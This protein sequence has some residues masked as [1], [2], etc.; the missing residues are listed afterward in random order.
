MDAVI[1]P[2]WAWAP[3]L[4]LIAAAHTAHGAGA[5]SSRRLA[6][7]RFRL[8]LPLAV[9]LA[10]GSGS[11][12]ATA[13]WLALLLVEAWAHYVDELDEQRRRER[14]HQRRARIPSQRPRHTMNTP[15]PVRRPARSF[16]A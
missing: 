14:E 12:P 16:R 8:L 10:A 11:V 7:L 4:P 15:V 6:R 2:W 13:L 9:L 1:L 5:I 3:L